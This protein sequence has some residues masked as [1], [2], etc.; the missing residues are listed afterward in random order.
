MRQAGPV[1]QLRV[2]G[3]FGGFRGIRLVFEGFRVEPK[4]V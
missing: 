4:S 1:T 2:F 3:I